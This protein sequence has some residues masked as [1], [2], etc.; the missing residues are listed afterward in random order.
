MSRR[1]LITR[2]GSGPCN[3]LMCSLMH[4]DPATV[5]I[6]CNID[7]F[8]LKQSPA[9]R[10]F[11]IA[12]PDSP[13]GASEAF[14]R[15]LRLVISRTCTDLIIPG[16]DDDALLLA[17]LHERNPLPCRT[18][19]PTAKTI[20]LCHDKYALYE[21]FRRHQIPVATTYPITDRASLD[22]AWRALNPRDL[23]WCRIRYGCASLGATKV[24]D[25][26]QAWHWITYWNTMRGVPVEHF[27]LCEFLPGR[28]FNVQGIWFEGRLVLIKMCERLSYLHAT[29]NP[30]GMGS[31]AA[32]AKTVWEPAAIAACEA[33]MQAVDPCA[34]GIF[35]LDMKG[36]EAGIPCVTE[37]NASR[38]VMITNFHDLI[39]RYNMAG[40]YARLGCGDSV[41]IDDPY[42][43]PGEYYLVRE[44]DTLP[45]IFKAE[46]LFQHIEKV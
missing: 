24:R 16:N 36:N 21:L 34:H 46:D 18:F 8:V 10:N 15:D 22:K 43:D 4:D 23:A 35:F 14:D 33:A 29:Q 25:V 3:N 12:S 27:T 39:G 7:R 40:T 9:Q 32:L 5:L 37:I 1:I 31:T 28:D 13:G 2:A 41:D 44:L 19:L 6:G 17:Q 20:A 45:A 26:D 11:L 42:D 38:F 30:S